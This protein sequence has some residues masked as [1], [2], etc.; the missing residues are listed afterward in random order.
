MARAGDFKGVLTEGPEFEAS[1]AL[2]GYTGVSDLSA[3]Y[4]SD[5]LCDEYGLDNIGL[6]ELN[7]ALAHGDRVTIMPPVAGG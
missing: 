7:V 5:R 1:G 4:L 6:Q 2:G 3:L